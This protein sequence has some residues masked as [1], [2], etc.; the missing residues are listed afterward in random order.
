MLNKV[1]M[2]GKGAVRAIAATDKNLGSWV[3]YQLSK[4]IC[5]SYECSIHLTGVVPPVLSSRGWGV[6]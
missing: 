3:V 5:L 4:F 1:G 2:S 6:T